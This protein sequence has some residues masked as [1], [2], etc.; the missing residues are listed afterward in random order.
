[1]IIIKRC[2]EFLLAVPFIALPAVAFGQNNSSGAALEL[3]VPH[4]ELTNQTFSESLSLL[5]G[6]PGEFHLAFEE[7]LK[8]RDP[9]PQS[10]DPR[11]SINL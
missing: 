2:L 8:G 3:R 1:M 7:I 5:S 9:E 6:Q 10:P 4:F 11:F